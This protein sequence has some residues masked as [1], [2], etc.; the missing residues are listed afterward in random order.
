MALAMKKPLWYGV[1]FSK[2]CLHSLIS[3]QTLLATKLITMVTFLCKV[4]R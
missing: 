1:F 2:F 3:F 4:Q